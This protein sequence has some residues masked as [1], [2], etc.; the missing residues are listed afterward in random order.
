MKSSCLGVVG[1]GLGG[2]L[3]LENNVLDND[4]SVN[5]AGELNPSSVGLQD[6]GGD[7]EV[8]GV[9]LGGNS[10]LALVGADLQALGA[11]SGVLNGCSK[12]VLGSTTVHVDGERVGDGALHELPLDA[13][14]SAGREAVC[15]LG[16]G[17]RG[18]VEMVLVAI[19]LVGDLFGNELVDIISSIGC[20]RKLTITT[21]F[22]PL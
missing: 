18:H 12:P 7:E 17:G 21:I 2:L 9:T 3:G 4:L 11:A 14:D 10:G 6:T 13:V 5:V 20:T 8:V 1:S 16:P 19:S 22:L 15:E